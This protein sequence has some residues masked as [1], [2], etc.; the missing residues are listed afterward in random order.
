[1]GVS[2]LMES[3]HPDWHYEARLEI[4]A[5]EG[6]RVESPLRASV[7]I[8]PNAM[9]EDREITISKGRLDSEQVQARE[10]KS[11]APAGPA[12][13]FGPEGALFASAV[14]IELPF[15]PPEGGE[16]GIHTWDPLEQDWVALRGEVDWTRRKVRAR[17]THFSL[18]QAMAPAPRPS[19]A[20]AEFGMHNAY[21][22]PNPARGGARPT[23]HVEAGLAD[24]LKIRIY[25][26]AGRLVHEARIEDAPGIVN[27]GSGPKYAYE[28]TWEGHIPSGVYF[29]AVEADKAGQGSVRRMGRMAVVR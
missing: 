29:Y 10:K 9:E 6:G 5:A 2:S 14:T 22:Y 4:S 13:E 15:S 25:D 8:D 21:V 23:L 18:Y 24:G 19:A 17:T 26:V 28:Y 3:A 20:S 7:E 12:F 11:I 1:M 16:V 27:D